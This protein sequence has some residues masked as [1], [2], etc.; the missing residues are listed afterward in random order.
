MPERDPA[1]MRIAITTI[2]AAAKEG[3]LFYTLDTDKP[4]GVPSLNTAEGT[5]RRLLH[6]SDQRIRYI[7]ASR[8][9]P[10]LVTGTAIEQ[11]IA[12]P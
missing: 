12:L 1:E 5:E 8:S 4:A 2:G 9:H 7:A 10:L 6:G 3:E 11:I